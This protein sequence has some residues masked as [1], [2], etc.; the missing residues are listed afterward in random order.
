MVSAHSGSI[1]N[2]EENLMWENGY[3]MDG[4]LGYSKAAGCQGSLPSEGGRGL[5]VL[6]GRW[7]RT[8][9]PGQICRVSKALEPEKW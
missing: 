5:G 7:I 8:D 9:A 1:L 6:T 2:G 3:R 4:V